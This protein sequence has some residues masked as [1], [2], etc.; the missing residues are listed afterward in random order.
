M[1]RQS[2]FLKNKKCILLLCLEIL[3]VLIGVFGAFSP[4]G[5]VADSQKS[6]AMFEEGIP[7]PAGV[8]T[9]R[10]YFEAPE[11]SQAAFGVTVEP[12]RQSS[13]KS[14]TVALRVGA[15]V[16]ECQFYLL[17]NVEKLTVFFEENSASVLQSMHVEIESGPEGSLIF[18]FW[19]LLVC[20]S[21]D[22]FLV[23]LL[24]HR[25]HP[26]SPEKQLALFGVPAAALLASLPLLTDY[27]IWG[28][29]FGFHTLRIEAL[30][31]KIL[32]GD[33]FSR[34]EGLWLNGHGY[35]SSLFYG[36]TFLLFP[37]FLRIMGFPLTE[38]Y[39]LFVA[40]VN[41]ATA[42]VAYLSFSRCL[43]SVKAGVFGM[44]LY[45]LSPY[46][47]YNITNRSAVGEFTAM[48]FFPLLIW[49]FYKIFTEDI[50]EKKYRRNWL[51][52]MIGFSGI[53]QSHVLSCEMV[54]AFVILLCLILWKKVFR[55]QTFLVL[56]KTVLVTIAV[57]AWFLI[58]FLD[59]MTADKYY[60]GFNQEALIQHRGVLPL[61]LFYT[62]QAP[63]NTSQ[64]HK[65]G[66]LGGE[67]VGLGAALLVCLVLWIFLRFG[68]RKQTLFG[69]KE[70]IAADVALILGGAALFMST[71]LFP[72][73]FLS[74]RS[75]VMAALVGALQFP[76]R[77]TA[78]ATLFAVFV[79]CVLGKGLLENGRKS[80]EAGAIL[81]GICF[82][83][84]IFGM[85]QMNEFLY[86]RSPVR[87]YSVQN[88]ENRIIQG[89]EYLPQDALQE[90]MTYHGPV[91]SRDVVLSD[92]QKDN[93]SVSAYVETG[94]GGDSYVEF[95]MLYYKGYQ[96]EAADT[97][98]PLQTV[99][100]AN[101]DVRVLLPENFSGN[102]Q[103]SYQGMWYWHM[104]VA[105]SV[106]FSAGIADRLWR[107][108][109]KNRKRRKL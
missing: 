92:Y 58:P 39:N 70:R 102:I 38:A 73:D 1:L 53:I 103:C 54:G 84:L 105:F 79:A 9:A 14:N 104:A 60:F 71:N 99:K 6:S 75:S 64:F 8:Y 81:G 98:E 89:A 61:H 25:R 36:D 82:L 13:L 55:R 72:W 15:G 65:Y 50:Q 97:G 100:G 44:A 47:L 32:S 90:H 45:T 62:L 22:A 27:A 23:L 51:I 34:V 88:M 76:T 3:L 109:F 29:D 74:T 63:G 96:A 35:A 107:E 5:I 66:M 19:V 41:F 52:P 26:I 59:M 49:G 11:G 33:F 68:K 18:L 86:T 80:R 20:L 2:G 10:V 108:K 46:R 40:A 4:K 93:L 56:V 31:Q 43:N 83:S 48:I 21:A 16:Q 24:Y 28:A 42:Y 101:A 69:E 91:C 94:R 77:L 85:Y 30:A 95:P 78:L 12:E 87:L 37:A 67:P 57:N 106:L 7:L 17:E